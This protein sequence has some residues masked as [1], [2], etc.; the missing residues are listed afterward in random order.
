MFA[1]DFTTRLF[2]LARPHRPMAGNLGLEV[3][4]ARPV[5]TLPQVHLGYGYCAPFFRLRQH[6]A[7]A[8]VNGRDRPVGRHVRVGAADEEDVVLARARR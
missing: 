1:T 3:A 5:K 4:E 2:L 6:L 8:V 7:F